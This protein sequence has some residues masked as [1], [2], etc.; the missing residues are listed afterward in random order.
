MFSPPIA[1]KQ[2]RVRVKPATQHEANPTTTFRDV[3]KITCDGDAEMFWHGPSDMWLQMLSMERAK[4]EKRA[5]DEVAASL[6]KA[7]ERAERMA[8][9]AAM[10]NQPVRVIAPEPERGAP[11][12][13]PKPGE[14]LREAKAGTRVPSN[15]VLEILTEHDGPM[16]VKTIVAKMGLDTSNIRNTIDVA[17]RCGYL[18]QKGLAERVMQGTY[19][20]SDRGKTNDARVQHDGIHLRAVPQQPDPPAVTQQQ[21]PAPEVARVAESVDDVIE[22]VLDLLLPQGFKAAHLRFIAPWVESTKRMVDAVGRG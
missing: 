7:A 20:I 8:A 14:L 4:A 13:N 19:R 16:T 9:D 3:Y 21:P 11:V 15:A 6:A 10:K 22:A 18:T 17:N 5:K 1:E 2:I 12:A